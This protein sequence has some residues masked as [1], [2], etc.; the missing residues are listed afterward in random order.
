MR[1]AAG[2]DNSTQFGPPQHKPRISRTPAD[3]L[4]WRVIASVRLASRWRWRRGGHVEEP[5]TLRCQRCRGRKPTSRSAEVRLGCFGGWQRSDVGE[6]QHRVWRASRSATAP[7]LTHCFAQGSV[8]RNCRTAAPGPS[9]Q[10]VAFCSRGPPG[11]TNAAIIFALELRTGSTAAQH[12]VV[13]HRVKTRSACP[14][15]RH[16]PA[17]HSAPSQLFLTTLKYVA[18]SSGSGINHRAVSGQWGYH[19]HGAAL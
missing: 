16:R 14:C 10:I 19:A 3:I 18:C 5:V 13:I 15:Q 7:V 17:A 1:A 12:Q 6:R 2:K 8:A 11:Q 9:R 4:N